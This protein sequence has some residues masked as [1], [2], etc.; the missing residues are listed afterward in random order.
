M[1]IIV[2][3]NEPNLQAPRVEFQNGL[4]SYLTVFNTDL[5]PRTDLFTKVITITDTVRWNTLSIVEMI[6]L[7]V[8]KEFSTTEQAL[9]CWLLA[10]EITLTIY[11]TEPELR[12][13]KEKAD[14]KLKICAVERRI[15]A[16]P[17]IRKNVR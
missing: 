4:D 3:L 6:D 2:S 11:S 1:V 8:R 15:V 10:M 13:Q 14:L 5:K 16:K 17:T 7:F 12:A 9:E